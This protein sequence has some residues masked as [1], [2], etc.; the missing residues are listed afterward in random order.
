MKIFL[1]PIAESLDIAAAMNYLEEEDQR[2]SESAVEEEHLPTSL[3]MD[4][5]H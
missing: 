2:V 1:G 3:Q 5:R 4:W